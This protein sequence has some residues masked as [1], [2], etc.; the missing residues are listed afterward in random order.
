MNKAGVAGCLVVMGRCRCDQPRSGMRVMIEM[1]VDE[2]RDEVVTVIVSRVAAQSQWL[3][4]CS[5]G[6]FR[7]GAGVQLRRNLSGEGL[8]DQD[9]VGERGRRLRHELA[10]VVLAPQ[11][12]IGTE[13]ASERFLPHGHC[14]GAQM[15]RMPTVT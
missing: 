1:I 8:I 4:G 15:G 6:V 14:V 2:G 7:T 11:C 12:A 13:I 9:A 10:G 5:T 3:F